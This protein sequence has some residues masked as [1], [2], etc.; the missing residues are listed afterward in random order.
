MLLFV[1]VSQY[2]L[3][4]AP[5]IACQVTCNASL[6]VNIFFVF[7]FLRLFLSAIS[8]SFEVDSNSSC[9][10]LIITKYNETLL[11]NFPFSFK[12]NV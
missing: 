8:S 9:I 7:C 10:L 5:A 12:K 6:F 11:L 2:V 4:I 3:P 1:P